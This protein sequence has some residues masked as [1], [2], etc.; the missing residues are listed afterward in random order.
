MHTCFPTI[1]SPTPQPRQISP[2]SLKQNKSHTVALCSP[3]FLST[4]APSRA[5][6]A[7]TEGD[8]QRS[9]DPWDGVGRGGRV[10]TPPPAPPGLRG[11]WV[12]VSAMPCHPG[13]VPILS[14]L[15]SEKECCH[16]MSPRSLIFSGSHHHRYYYFSPDLLPYPQPTP[17]AQGGGMQPR[18]AGTVW[19]LVLG[20]EAGTQQ[21]SK[22]ATWECPPNASVPGCCL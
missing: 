10:L 4:A 13:Q 21:F 6:E 7:A 15:L 12:L 9:R 18:T 5:W 11:A 19:S 16:Q 22:W 8:G 17:G 20:V 3:T 2:P 14:D 1:L